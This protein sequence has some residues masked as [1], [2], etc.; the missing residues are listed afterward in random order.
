MANGSVGVS[1]LALVPKLQ[2]GWKKGIEA[3]LGTVSGKSGGKSGEEYSKGFGSKLGGIT[4]ALKGAIG[5]AAIGSALKEAVGSFAEYEQL[6]GGVEKLYK[7]S[8]DI[9]KQ[10]AADA[11]KTVGMSANDY[12]A[13]A[14]QFSASMTASLGGD[15]Q[16]SAAQT[17]KAMEVISDNVNV[18][19]SNMEDVT[20]AFKGF[21]KQNYTMLDNLKLGY[22]G[23]KEEM[24][25]LLDD[26]SKISGVEYD[27]G[28]LS[29]LTD[30]IQVVQTE[31]G[32]TGTTAKEAS[33]TVE[34]S[35][36]SLK[37]AWDNFV[38]GLGSG[39]DMQQLTKSLMDSALTAAKNIVPVLG[40]VVSSLGP[41][42]M[43]MVGE[44]G[45]YLNES[46]PELAAKLG[47]ALAET[48]GSIVTNLPAF[49]EG[50][51]HLLNGLVDTI[52][53]FAGTIAL[54]FAKL[55]VAGGLAIGKKVGDIKDGV[56]QA[57]TGGLKSVQGFFDDFAAAGGNLIDGLIK[58]IGDA[59]DRV[60]QKIKDIAKG[61]VDTFKS[62]LGIASPSKVMAKMGGYMMQGLTLGIEGGGSGAVSAMRGVASSL[63]GA[64]NVSITSPAASR[65]VAGGGITINLNYSADADANQM[66]R[67]I[68]AALRRLNM[69]EGV[70][71]GC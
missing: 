4:S 61:A 15:V 53:S 50:L 3:E 23:T 28:S 63:Q 7:G 71:Y 57:I 67:D 69:A 14:T 8:A 11:Y 10:Y 2:S 41:A 38:T 65:S 48:A 17:Q 70:S 35:L 45:D 36:A 51:G 16:K 42:V 66:V 64:A 30:A 27:I 33:G 39:G 47:E 32:I 55:I 46:G 26:A 52:G 40:S 12:M 58:G 5:A 24:Q 37:G 29:D 19:G 60:V 9:V 18:F 21:S 6:V 59:K 43:E 20:N 25:R 22:G 54:A 13:T 49:A 31:M 56:K 62:W 1:Y 44:I 68:A 34:G